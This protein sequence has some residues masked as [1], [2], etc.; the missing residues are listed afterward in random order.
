[1]AV[2]SEGI[3]VHVMRR[4]V[5]F[6][7]SSGLILSAFECSP[8]K[9]SRAEF[10]REAQSLRDAE[11]RDLAREFWREHRLGNLVWDVLQKMKQDGITRSN[12]KARHAERYSN[13][14]IHVDTTGRIL[15]ELV[16]Q[17]LQM[18]TVRTLDSLSVKFDYY[19][20]QLGRADSEALEYFKHKGVKILSINSEKRSGVL[21]WIPFDVL[22]S[23][24]KW[25]S[26][27]GTNSVFFPPEHGS[28]V[29]F[30]D[31]KTSNRILRGDA[32]T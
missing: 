2:E 20:P 24:A 7:V 3:V 28:L 26:I 32:C 4:C 10:L 18:A 29:P 17:D 25:P 1:M 16:F 6:L 5:I 8:K 30:G 27:A 11:Q 12:A 21:C 23:I 15:T 19:T 14:A 31:K 9:K 22:E 13:F